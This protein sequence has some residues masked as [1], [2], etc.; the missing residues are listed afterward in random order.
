MKIQVGIYDEGTGKTETKTGLQV[1]W[2]HV[3]KK[4]NSPEQRR[5]IYRVLDRFPNLDVVVLDS[6]GKGDVVADDIVEEWDRGYLLERFLFNS[7]SKQ[8]LSDMFESWV[9]NYRLLVPQVPANPHFRSFFN[10][11]KLL[12]RRSA[13]RFS[14]FTNEGKDDFFDSLCLCMT[15]INSSKSRTIESSSRLWTPPSN[16]TAGFAE[17]RR[18]L[19]SRGEIAPFKKRVIIKKNRMSE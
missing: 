8:T 13:G 18:E 15:A 6:T 4:G 16:H 11:L 1:I 17:L 7:P 2:W 19:Y 10:E 14:Y 3:V 12:Q 5:E 9:W